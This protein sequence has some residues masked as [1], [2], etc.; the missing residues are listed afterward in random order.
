MGRIFEEHLIRQVRS[1]NGV[2]RFRKDPNDCG[3]NADWFLAIPE[4]ESTVVPSVWNTDKGNLTYE[5]VAWYEKSFH[6]DGGCLRF[7]FGSIMT[8]S[9]VWL[10]GIHIGSHYGGFTQFEIITPDVK[11]GEHRLTVRVDNRFDEHSIPQAK[12]D[13][14]HYGGIPRDVSVETLKGICVL[15]NRFEYTLSDDF[16]SADG[17]FVL[18]LYNAEKEKAS[19]D[20]TVTLAEST[21]VRTS[22]EL[23]GNAH[24]TLTLPEFQVSGIELWD[25]GKPKL[26][27]VSI[28]SATDDLRD[29]VGFRKIEVKDQKVFLN[30]RSVEFR[31]VNRHEEHPDWGFALP[32]NIEKRDID[33]AL[34][35]GCNAIRGSHYPNAQEFVD[36][37]DERGMMF[38]SEIPIWGGG[39]SEEALAD[40]TVIERGL[41]MHREMLRYYYNHPCIV[42][43]GLHNEI[44]LA[45]QA[46]YNISKKYYGYLKENGG[47]RLVVY[48]SDKPMDDVCFEFCDVICLNQY[49]GW[50]YGF[51]P[52]AW[53]NFL[54]R[55]CE[56]RKALGMEN[57]P[58]IFS[59]FGCAALY[60]CHD[61]EDILWSEENQAKQISHCLEVF[62]EHPAVVGSFIWQFCDIRTCFE[63][64]INRARGF[65][66]KGLLNEYRKPKLAYHAARRLYNKFKGD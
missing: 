55:F 66:N 50:Y 33:L 2:W 23:D 31:G 65:N 27:D 6:T 20:I 24:L 30:G 60:G 51:E 25:I 64:G 47:N 18:E 38:W 29:R 12:T 36:L 62:H 49:F 32:L 57:K 44:L 16:S 7:C 59:E 17:K 43:W 3:K 28:S 22:V 48:A 61:D 8:E 19:T 10:D 35:M 26:Y 37:L 53:E 15:S 9:D 56:R 46:A 11:A 21:V 34:E 63:M 42:I 41:E 5:G 52:D 14:Y 39:F 58:I 45:T 13:W 1:L 4:S 40:P 54:E